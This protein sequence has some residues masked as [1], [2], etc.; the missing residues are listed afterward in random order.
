MD[1]LYTC[2]FKKQ[3]CQIIILFLVGRLI[4]MDYMHMNVSRSFSWFLT[5]PCKT[6]LN[7]PTSTFLV[8]SDLSGT[9]F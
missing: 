9:I 3:Y 1:I 7:S 5:I 2:Y 4:Y 6:H 8:S